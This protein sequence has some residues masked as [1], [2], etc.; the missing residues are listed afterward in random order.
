[1]ITC[2]ASTKTKQK[3][4]ASILSEIE[5]AFCRKAKSKFQ[6]ARKKTEKALLY[7]S[8]FVWSDTTK[9][10]VK[11]QKNLAAFGRHLDQ[12]RL[13]KNKAE[14][15]EL[16]KS[17]IKNLFDDTQDPLKLFNNLSEVLE[18]AI[19]KSNACKH[20]KQG[21]ALYLQQT[22]RYIAWY[23]ET[24]D[25]P[26]DDHQK[27]NQQLLKEQNYHCFRD[28]KS[29]VNPKEEESYL[30]FLYPESSSKPGASLR[31]DQE[32]LPKII[33]LSGIQKEKWK[34][35]FKTFKKLPT[36]EDQWAFMKSFQKLW[37]DASFVYNFFECCPESLDLC[38]EHPEKVGSFLK[39]PMNA[40]N[41][42][43]LWTALDLVE[44][45]DEDRKNIQQGRYDF[46]KQ[47]KKFKDLQ[48]VT[49]LQYKNILS[50]ACMLS[51]R[52]DFNEDATKAIDKSADE[53]FKAL[54]FRLNKDEENEE[55]KAILRYVKTLSEDNPAYTL[56]Q[57]QKMKL[58]KLEKIKMKLKDLTSSG[59][60]SNIKSSLAFKHFLKQVNDPNYA[61]MPEVWI[62]LGIADPVAFNKCVFEALQS[63][64]SSAFNS[65]RKAISELHEN[66][67][68]KELTKHHFPAELAKKE[69][70]LEWFAEKAKIEGYDFSKLEDVPD[71]LDQESQTS[72]KT[73]L[74]T[75]KSSE[76]MVLTK[77][78][79]IR[80]TPRLAA[81][82]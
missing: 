48:G 22:L 37:L 31:E 78:I 23:L 13:N 73:W 9:A 64:N 34:L 81:A 60:Y 19:P 76:D 62:L 56:Q 68:L 80:N 35:I 27:K 59:N 7:K 45:L 51:P 33:G 79:A 30:S 46:K 50:K 53:A 82:A 54:K 75:P 14:Q 47:S 12:C 20:L 6:D 25:T 40:K 4:Q 2:A 61:W 32:V 39:K 15:E 57:N 10:Q 38:L 3:K 16:V 43:I 44:H 52:E 63:K 77:I 36:E 18:K 29:E 17:E 24:Q 55:I 28:F 1:M 49:S 67:G 8:L 26:G 65:I 69:D 42:K 58:R 71:S 74:K 66:H 72:L 5:T 11:L 41:K 21:S 70:V